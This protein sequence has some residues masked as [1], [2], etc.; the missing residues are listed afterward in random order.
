MNALFNEKYRAWLDA[1]LIQFNER[2]KDNRKYH[3][4]SLPDPVNYDPGELVEIADDG[5]AYPHGA[6]G[7]NH[8]RDAVTPWGE[9]EHFTQ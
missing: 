2:Y 4:E 8:I 1:S 6:G 3:Q 5:S 9:S 7:T